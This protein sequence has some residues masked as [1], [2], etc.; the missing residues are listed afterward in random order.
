MNKSRIV[1]TIISCRIWFSCRRSKNDAR[2]GENER[3]VNR[4]G[5]IESLKRQP[6]GMCRG[7]TAPARTE[8]SSLVGVSEPALFPPLDTFNGRVICWHKTTRHFVAIVRV[9]MTGVSVSIHLA[10][11][12]AA[13][14][15]AFPAGRKPRDDPLMKM[16]ADKMLSRRYCW[17]NVQLSTTFAWHV[18]IRDVLLHHLRTK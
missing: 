16:R 13:S 2:F 3:I 12:Y 4:C 5:P 10:A 9:R 8:L 14:H 7:S 1:R 15:E 18:R 11:G 17:R 6:R